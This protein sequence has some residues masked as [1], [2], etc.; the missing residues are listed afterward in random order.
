[1]NARQFDT[2]LYGKQ[3]KAGLFTDLGKNLLL[4]KAIF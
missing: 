1:M 2:P 4:I 3:E